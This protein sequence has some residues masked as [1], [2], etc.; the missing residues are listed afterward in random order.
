MFKK[1]VSVVLI[2][3]MLMSI[4]VFAFAN[5]ASSQGA[6]LR[7]EIDNPVYTYNGLERESIDGVAPFLSAYGYIMLPLRTV[8]EALGANVSWN[9]ETRTVSIVKNGISLSIAVDEP[10]PDGMGRPVIVDG[11]TFVPFEYVT[12]ELGVTTSW[13]STTR[14]FYVYDYLHVPAPVIEP[15]APEVFEV[16]AEEPVEVEEYVQPAVAADGPTAYELLTKASDALLEAGSVLMTADMNIAMVLDGE[17]LGTVQM[18]SVISQII[19]SETDID[20]KMESTTT[21]EG[22]TFQT[23]TYFR[24]GVYY[25][26]ILGEQFR[27]PMPLEDLMGQTG[28]VEFPEHAVIAQDTAVV[29]GRTQLSFTISGTAMEDFISSMMGE[30]FNLLGLDGLNMQLS[31]MDITAVLDEDGTM[32]NMRSTMTLTMAF[33]GISISMAMDM[34]TEVVQIGGVTIDFPANLDDFVDLEL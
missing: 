7:F 22:E 25:V 31:N 32:H 29:G 34:L 3:S 27:M 26:D 24:D 30:M 5:E 15:V 9:G 23:V 2:I 14:I 6:T 20:M 11:R 4:S 13:D 33:E 28:L 21:V 18:T 17:S 8:A 16:P 12:Q 10:L 19:R 1:V